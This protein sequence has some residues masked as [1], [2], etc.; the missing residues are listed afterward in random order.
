MRSLISG[1]SRQTPRNVRHARYSS[2]LESLVYRRGDKDPGALIIS[3]LL[4]NFTN[5]HTFMT[6]LSPKGV[7]S[8]GRGG[9]VTS[10][11]PPPINGVTEEEELH[12]VHVMPKPPRYFFVIYV[13]PNMWTDARGNR[14]AGVSGGRR[15]CLCRFLALSC[16]C[17]AC[18]A[19]GKCFGS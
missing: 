11:A 10:Q 7:L 6:S 8:N 17:L 16:L 19:L 1:A 5:R 15:G 3:Q 4:Y 12:R 9:R 13:L 2:P 18:G 14:Q